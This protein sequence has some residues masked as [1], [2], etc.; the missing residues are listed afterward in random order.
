VDDADCGNGERGAEGRGRGVFGWVGGRTGSG[1]VEDEEDEAG[2][3]A[4]V[5]DVLEGRRSAHE[6]ETRPLHADLCNAQNA[7]K[8][9]EAFD[10]LAARHIGAACGQGQDVGEG[11]GAAR[12]A[13]QDEIGRD[14]VGCAPA[15]DPDMLG[16][17]GNQDADEEEAITRC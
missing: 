12:G 9:G 3:E 6:E 5:W 8:A 7:R 15:Y 2:F 1:E 4:L 11:A 13:E 17:V 16:K 14:P 10:L